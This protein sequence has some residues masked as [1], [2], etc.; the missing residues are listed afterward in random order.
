MAISL[1]VIGKFIFMDWLKEKLLFTSIVALFWTA[2]IIYLSLNQKHRLQRIGFNK[3]NILPVF[4]LIF[5]FAVL[6]IFISLLVGYYL[7]TINITWHILPVLLTYPIWGIIQQF[8]IMGVVTGNLEDLKQ[9]RSKPVLIIIISA[10]LFSAIHFPNHWLMLGTFA[11]AM[12]YSFIYLKKKNLWVLGILHGWIGAIYF[13]TI[14]DRD[15]F[16]EMFGKFL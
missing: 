9:T 11:L 7:E 16:L 10:I 8:L 3:E 2:Y 13:Y 5:P 14:V 15:P 6:S 4:K 12:F 1:T